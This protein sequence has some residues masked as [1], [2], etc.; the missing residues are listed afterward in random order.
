[1]TVKRNWE[2]ILDPATKAAGVVGLLGPIDHIEAPDPRSLVVTL[3][4]TY[5]LFLQGIW[6]PYFG[7][8]SS[9]TLDT[10]KP[11]EQ[12]QTLVGSGPFRHTG[13]TQD[14]AVTLEAY[15]DYAWGSELLKNRK[16]PYVQSIRLR[17]MAEQATRVSTLES[18]E[19]LLIDEVSE[20]DYNRLKSDKRFIFADA[21]R[22]GLALG[23]FVNVAKPPTDDVAVRQA[24]NYA[25][26]R[27]A[28]V[29]RLFFG[30]HR[31]TVGPLAE[32]VWGRWDGAEQLFGF[33]AKKAAQILDDA[34]WKVAAG[35]PIREKNSQKLS[36]VLATFRSPWSELAEILQSQ[37]R[38]IGIDLQ[39]QKMERGP[40]LDFTRNYQH[41]LCASA[42]TNIDPDELRLRYHSKNRPATNFANLK[43]DQL[44]AQLLTGSQQMLNSD[45]RRQTYEAIQRRL[46]EILPF[47]S[48]MSQ[49]R[50]EAMSARVNDLRMGPDG[51]NALQLTDVWLD[52]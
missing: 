34:G 49:V 24:M 42:G 15:P 44:D 37:Y 3:K 51:L 4:E 38:G 48:V 22:R 2:R 41:N 46:M 13:R 8:M 21:P 26:D 25:I 33:D 14:G 20:P 1:M 29:E 17:Y 7:I 45:E 19:S 23:F 16:A 47:V 35:S 31:P 12:V 40:Y 28:I 27:K 9:K 6:R 43:D 36:V 11:G 39:V 10:L 52:A 50:V 18:G 32:G 30:V 5:P